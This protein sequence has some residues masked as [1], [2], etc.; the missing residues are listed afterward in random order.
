[1]ATTQVEL[2]SPSRTLFT[3]EAEMLVC[4]TVGGEIAFLAE[5]MPYIGLLESGVVR[6]VGPTQVPEGVDA[7]SGELRIAVHGGVV[8][9]QENQ[10]IL[11]ADVAE[12]A[13]EI[14]VERARRAR[15][16]AEQAV[17]AG[18]DPTAEAALRRATVRLEVAG[19]GA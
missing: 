5:H 16:A 10:V 1:M 15:D 3:G 14:D 4:R 8:E 6:V 13:D 18:D 12:L 11:L 9:V 17:T 19:A 7:G 2:V